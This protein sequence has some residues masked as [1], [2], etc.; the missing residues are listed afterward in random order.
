MSQSEEE[1]PA[2]SPAGALALVEEGAFLLDV[3]EEHEWEAGHAPQAAHL[4]M[5]Q[6]PD[7]LDGLPADRPVV[8]VCHVGGRSAAVAGFL[9]QAGLDARN[10]AGG[11]EAWAAAGLPVVD[12][13]GG[14]GRVG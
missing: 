13:G 1:V 7:G 4:P 6:V 2:V 3:R 9:R 8:C 14:P 5:G 11:M 10:L 12:G